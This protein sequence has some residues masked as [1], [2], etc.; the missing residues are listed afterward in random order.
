VTIPEELVAKVTEE[1]IRRLAAGSP[2]APAAP[3]SGG[4]RPD[5]IVVG[6]PSD[7]LGRLPA[8]AAQAVKSAYAIHPVCSFEAEGLPKVPVLLP[9]LPIQPLVR[10]AYGDEGCTVEG[11]Q[12]LCAL[13]E[14]RKA[15]VWED[16]IVWRRYAQ[17]APKSLVAIWRR[18]EAALMEAGV[19]IVSAG[20]ILPALSGGP[21]AAPGPLPPAWSGAGQRIG[22]DSALPPSSSRVLTEAKVMELFPKGSGPGS[23]SLAPGELLTPLAKDW[24]AAQKIQIR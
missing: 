21:K 7:P 16:G 2:P 20:E 6:P 5:L 17:T 19:C 22:P 14:G 18:C 1:I 3:A 24:L 13:L 23:L 15:V 8:E 4:P 11:R 12:L 10:V 9:C